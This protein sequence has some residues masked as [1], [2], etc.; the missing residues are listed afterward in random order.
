MKNHIYTVPRN[1]S[2]LWVKERII[3][4]DRQNISYMTKQGQISSVKENVK[5]NIYLKGDVIK[6]IW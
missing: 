5:G 3:P 1:L 4:S 6:N 2:Y